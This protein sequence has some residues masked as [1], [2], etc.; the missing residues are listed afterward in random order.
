MPMGKSS[1]RTKNR[2]KRAKKKLGAKRMAAIDRIERAKKRKDKPAPPTTT[3]SKPKPTPTVRTDPALAAQIADARAIGLSVADDTSAERVI[4]L[5]ERFELALTYVRDVWAALAADGGPGPPS[6]DLRH[7]T[8]RLFSDGR[9]ADGV[10]K[11]QQ[12]READ[13]QS[14]L[15]KD[16]HYRDVAKALRERFSQFLPARSLWSRLLGR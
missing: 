5:L 13:P 2:A 6:D 12:Q 11:A 16:A 7:V 1:K 10:V 14:P 4:Q 9:V 8:A 3:P 15:P